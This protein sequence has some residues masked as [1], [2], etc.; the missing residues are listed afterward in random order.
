MFSNLELVKPFFFH[1]NDEAE[2]IFS[3]VTNVKIYIKKLYEFFNNTLSA[4][5]VVWSNFQK[6][7]ITCNT[8]KADCAVKIAENYRQSNIIHLIVFKFL[9]NLLFYFY[10]LHFNYSTHI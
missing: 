9:S 8:F 1:P 2:R 3:M 7:N 4:I 6:E 5:C 10:F